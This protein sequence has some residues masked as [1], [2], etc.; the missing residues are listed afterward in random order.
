VKDCSEI[1]ELVSRYAYG[2]EL[3]AE[4]KGRIDGHLKDCTVCSELVDFVRKTRAIAHKD[5]IRFKPPTGPCPASDT[6]IALEEGTLDADAAR[7][8]KLH[9][10]ACPTCRQIFLHLRILSREEVEDRVHEYFDAP[11]VTEVSV[12][13]GYRFG[14]RVV[15]LKE[16]LKS[17]VRISGTGRISEIGPAIRERFQASSREK[18]VFA[19]TDVLSDETGAESVVSLIVL[20]QGNNSASF[21]MECTPLRSEWTAD[22]ISVGGDRP[23]SQPLD[24]S[25][26]TIGPPASR[27]LYVVSVRKMEKRLANF[28]IELRSETD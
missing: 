26:Q 2:A 10:L 8:T 7:T 6:L 17:N 4:E 13:M 19:I 18:I 20:S 15:P 28:I 25:L 23:T 14:G 16:L 3:S 24:T 12:F 21:V 27:G 11:N 1:D 9:L 5:P 22:V